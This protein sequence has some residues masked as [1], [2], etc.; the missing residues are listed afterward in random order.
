[1]ANLNFQYL[2]GM[3]QYTILLPLLLF[4]ALPWVLGSCC[5]ED[6]AL[7]SKTGLRCELI[8]D[9]NKLVKVELIGT[10]KEISLQ[11]TEGYDRRVPF[12][13][14]DTVCHLRFYLSDRYADTPTITRTVSISYVG[15]PE[16]R[17]DGCEDHELMI[18]YD[19]SVSATTFSDA[20]ILTNSYYNNYDDGPTLQME[21]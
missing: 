11:G 17:D 7:S 21:D 15:K 8:S 2:A 10:N 18:H 4:S 16:Y 1:M 5:F 20:R 13:P 19:A 6:P 14:K 3:K 12:N 9:Q